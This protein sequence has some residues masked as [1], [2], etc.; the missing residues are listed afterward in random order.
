MVSDLRNRAFCLD[1]SEEEA[2]NV[3]RNLLHQYSSA[4]D[5]I[6][7]TAFKAIL[8]AAQRL[9]ITSL[10]TLRIE[11]RSIKKLLH[12]VG[13][14]DLRK[15]KILLFF[16]YLL[17]KYGE[18]IVE[19]QKVQGEAYPLSSSNHQSV[20]VE[21]RLFSGQ[22]DAQMNM[23]SAAAVPEQFICPLA[24]RVMYDPV[25]IASGETFERMYIQKWF[26]EGQ[27][28]CPKTKKTLPHLSVT[29]NTALKELITKWCTENKANVSDPSLPVVFH[30][31][32]TSSCSIASLSSSLND[33]SLPIDFSNILTGSSNARQ[34]PGS[35]YPT[36]SN[37]LNMMSTDSEELHSGQ[38]NAE[39][40][41]RDMQILFELD[42]LPWELRSKV[43]Q[44]IKISEN[45]EHQTCNS[46]SCSNLLHIVQK[47]LKDARDLHD[48]EAQKTG[49]VF[50]L[51]FLKNCRYY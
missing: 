39:T 47:F 40:N 37:G 18:L 23:S 6:E 38:V 26:D 15:K 30:Q 7:E 12:E 17:S 31:L 42:I 21:S 11:Q 46:T 20:K 35:S 25:I 24:L 19:K 3:L 32:E 41:K 51:S 9:G 22:E 14:N 29:P 33:L 50:L 34:D 16:L 45:Y 13:E 1:P 36:I 10:K 48:V 43:I 2:G 4:T 5:S 8:V 44:D 28:T 49:C 27:H